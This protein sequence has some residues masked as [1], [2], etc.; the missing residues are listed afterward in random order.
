MGRASARLFAGEGAYVVCADIM[1]DWAK[2]TVRL[3]EEDGR[4]AVVAPCDVTKEADV[5]AA[6]EIAASA[7]GRLDVMFN[8]A[9]VATPAGFPAFEEYD[10]AQWDRLMNINLRGV[11]YGMKHAIRRFKEQGGG[12]VI[13][14]TGSVAGMVG[15]GGTV[16]GTSKG[17][18]VQMTRAVAIE[19]APFDI[20]VNAI[21]PAGMPRRTS[22]CTTSRRP[23]GQ[24]RRGGP[25]RRRHAS[26][27]PADHAR[28]LRP[29]GAVPGVGH[30]PQRHR[31]A[32]ARRR[33]VHRPMSG[34]PRR[35]PADE[36]RRLRGG[37]SVGATIGARLFE[38]GREVVLIARGEHYRVLARDGLRYSDPE[39]TRV[40][41]I[42]VV[43]HPGALTWGADVVVLAMKGQDTEPALRV[44]EA[45]APPDVVLLCAQNGIE[46]ERTALRRF[47][48]VYG[49]CVMMPAT[50]V[51]PGVVDAD[52][53]PIVGVLDVGRYPSGV[54]AVAEGIAADLAASGFRSRADPAI[55]AW[56]YEKLLPT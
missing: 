23:S 41:P 42:P 8:N 46:N 48:H 54:D 19:V 28:R 12:G 5:V 1:D 21:C 27:R 30:R 26:A 49:M 17:G 36:V 55:M 14:N 11:F 39:A 20:R 24:A 3:I 45:V 50:N 25:A 32:V 29:G 10:D 56:K 44:L 2:E 35:D 37:R 15:W 53:L 34:P 22:A 40:L 6:V 52:S 7:Y 51:E 38:H 18:V 4:S 33:W 47:A 31:G 9:G 13:V 16:Y 43:D